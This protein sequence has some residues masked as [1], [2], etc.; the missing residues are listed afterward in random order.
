MRFAR[1]ALGPVLVVVA[2]VAVQSLLHGRVPAAISGLAVVA[3]AL[4]VYLFHARYV[5]RRDPLELATQR[6]PWFASGTLLGAGLIAAVILSLA[7]LGVYRVQGL[8][9]YPIDLA[10]AIALAL[11]SGVVEEILFRG[12]LFRWLSRWSPWAAL[13]VTSAIFGFAHGHNP[14]ATLFSSVAIA[15]EAGVLLGAAYWLSGNL[16]FPIGIHAGWNFAEGTIFSTP[17]SGMQAPGFIAG[18]LS[19]PPLLTGGAFGVEASIVAVALCTLAGGAMLA[20][21]VVRRA[22]PVA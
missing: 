16:W 13:L 14:H 19:G 9:P 7:G 5:E 11:S 2:V 17:V 1:A 6:L 4:A 20:L 10:G 8:A 15:L 3:A 18:T 22:R 21:C 12:Y